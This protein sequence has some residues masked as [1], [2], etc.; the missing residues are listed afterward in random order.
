MTIQEEVDVDTNNPAASA[1]Y[2]TGTSLMPIRKV[3]GDDQMWT[4][5]LQMPVGTECIFK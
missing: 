3:S 2:Q 4:L 5:F 1:S